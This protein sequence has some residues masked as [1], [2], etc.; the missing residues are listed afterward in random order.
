MDVCSTSSSTVA[1]AAAHSPHRTIPKLRLC[2]SVS[3]ED[4]NSARRCTI[5]DNQLNI[6]GKNYSKSV[7]DN[8][9]G[10]DNSPTSIGEAILNDTISSVLAGHDATILAMGAKSTGKDE[11]L[12]G[13][14][15]ARN[16]LVQLAITQIMNALEE[17]KCPDERMQ[18]RMSVVMVSQREASIVDLLSPFNPDPRHR[19]VRIVD[20]AKIGVFLDNESEIRVDSVDQALFYLNTAVDH[21]LIQDEQTHRTNHVLI[22]LS[23]YT[24]KLTEQHMEGGRRRLS[25]L[26]MG[27]G[28]RNSTNGG[29]T[30]PVLG[31][32]LLALIQKNKHIPSRDSSACQ[33]IRCALSSSR[34]STFL[35]SF[36]ARNDDN[37]NIAHLACK[38][39][40]TRVKNSIASGRKTMTSNSEKGLSSSDTAR[41][42]KDFESGSELSSAAE[43]VIFVGPSSRT[44]S[45]VKLPPTAGEVRP[46]HRTTRTNSDITKPLTIDIKTSPTHSCHN[47]CTQ[48]VAP[49]LKG[50]TPFLSAS[51]KLYDELCSPPG[52]SIGS[53]SAFGGVCREER[54]DF[55]VM[56]AT[57]THPSK[58][59]S[60]YNLD[61]GKR[62]QILDWM[63]TADV[64]PVLFTTPVFDNN[65]EEKRECV[66]ILSHPLEDIIEQ[67][68]ESL[69]TSTATTGAATKSEDHPLR[70]LSKQN[71]AETDSGESQKE[72][73]ENELEL[74]MAASLSSM[75]SHD[76][77]AKLEAMRNTNTS[78]L[79]AGSST[80]V[81]DD[82][83]SEMDV[84]RRASHLEEYAMQR[85]REIEE[86]KPQKKKKKVNLNCCQHSMVS[87]GSTVV[88][89][90]LIEK[91]KEQERK[92]L[93]E[94]ARKQL[95]RERRNKLK[96]TE[97]ELRKE[98][99]MIDKELDDKRSLATS[100]AR[101]LQHFSLSPCRGSKGSFSSR[102]MSSHRIDPP[103]ASLPSTPTLS[104]R[105]SA[106]SSIRNQLSQGCQSATHQ[107]L[108]RHTKLSNSMR[109]TSAERK[110][111]KSSTRAS[112][113]TKDRRNSGGS[114]ERQGSK[115]ELCWRS[116]YAN[117]TSPK[118]Y[119]GP[120]TSSSGRGSSAPGSDFDGTVLSGSTTHMNG[121]TPRD[122]AKR[123]KRQSYS[124]SSGYE[125]A[126][127]DYHIYTKNSLFEKRMNEERM[128][129][130]RQTDQIRHR[131]RVLKKDLEEAKRAIGQIDDARIIANG[132]D[133]HRFHGLN[134]ATLID[135]LQQ[136]NKILE[137]RIVA[138]R[139]H[140]MLI[141]TFI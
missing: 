51:L 111:S 129:F 94:E 132:S 126:S 14:A 81:D 77:L 86:N 113:K 16:G 92:T 10:P 73:A 120:G 20:D 70:I 118:T 115:D 53:P 95:L 135:T 75:K 41:I 109:K 65:F 107:S 127:N 66:G 57:P 98:R 105:K 63:E 11:R 61:D 74:V 122:E 4:A 97:L 88:D 56:I 49:M 58:C 134:R 1:K 40:R 35:L 32:I 112:D 62:R 91:K 47:N 27:I 8:I 22:S 72:K 79:S 90:S 45:P 33:L 139:N 34:L 138:C 76:I 87:S 24:Y 25:F 7:F 80:T 83:M 9:F 121:T 124:A 114:Q 39:A 5:G 117:V 36:G 137:K 136:E 119:G 42:R 17:N 78:G 130:T 96:I 68:E 54:E 108:P 128:N 31:S 99:N 46:L 84:Y 18:V 104:Q 23:L 69:R 30:M 133:H 28:E 103:M 116:P 93:E 13:D 101:Q 19:N 60:R 67:E 29:L 140:S 141:T 37:E 125:S 50:H 59:R 52:S 82:K 26:D 38:I 3:D 123:S 21:R 43:T 64:S 85:V 12:Y 71:L 48:S 131:Q 55:G 106:A 100:I 110:S 2:I 102:S 89:W 6:E 44:V 15:E